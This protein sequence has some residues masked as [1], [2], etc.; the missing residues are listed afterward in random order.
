MGG[1][2]LRPFCTADQLLS[3]EPFGI[4]ALPDTVKAGSHSSIA[5]LSDFTMRQGRM[6]IFIA[7]HELCLFINPLYEMLKRQVR[8]SWARPQQAPPAL[9]VCLMPFWKELAV[10]AACRQLANA[11][12]SLSVLPC[13]ATKTAG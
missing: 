10:A 1:I 12:G 6:Q 4:S 5:I 11:P 8:T 7:S 3:G 9:S 2:S 13:F